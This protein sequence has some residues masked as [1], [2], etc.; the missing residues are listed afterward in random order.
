MDRVFPILIIN[1]RPAAGKSEILAYLRGLPDDQRRTRFHIG[2]MRVIDD[3]PMLWAWF[4]EDHILEQSFSLPRLHTTPDE[5]F[6]LPEFWHVLI[7]RLNL[8]YAK[9]APQAPEQSTALIEFSRGSQHGGYA[10]AYPHLGDAVLER[11]ACL[12]IRVRFEESQRKNRLRYRPDQAGS[13]LHHS[14]PDEKLEHLYRNDDWEEFTSADPH[15]LHVGAH[16]LPYA[17]FENDDDVTTQ[18]G[19]QLEV[20]LQQA[21]DELWTLWTAK[22]S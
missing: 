7:Q 3:F 2:T 11:A 4:E 9:W 6:R 13:I 12:Y 8:E 21:L 5:Y 17:I 10:C 18:P 15:Y 22:D 1:A 16:R 19:P 20:R 14:L